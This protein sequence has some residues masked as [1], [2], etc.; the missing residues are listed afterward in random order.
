MD[1]Q[2]RFEELKAKKAWMNPDLRDEYN[3]LKAEFGVPAGS[4]EKPDPRVAQLEKELAE[5][6]GLLL[7]RP[8]LPPQRTEGGWKKIEDSKEPVR[9]ATL[10]LYR[11]DSDDEYGYI[12]DW[13]FHK[14][15]FN[16]EIRDYE[17]EYKLT[18]LYADNT[19]KDVVMS[20]K[21]WTDI[22]AIETVKI[23]EMKKE[24]EEK[25]QGRKLSKVTVPAVQNG[26]THSAMPEHVA[27][28]YEGSEQVPLMESRHNITCKV[29]LADG[30]IIDINAD[31]LNQ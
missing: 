18:V 22:Q 25:H 29:E 2:K 20:L 15:V 6:K 16:D 28:K 24:L 11:A 27:P 4:T 21:D 1:R 30:R 8:E 31:R 23:I 12:I 26:Y 17:D 5:L 14:K 9:E 19:T 3:T 10:R 13:R 7:S